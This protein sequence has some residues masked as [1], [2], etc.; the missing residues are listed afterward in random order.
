MRSERSATLGVDART[1]G[2]R[3]RAERHRQALTL[4]QLAERCNLT[5]STLSQIERGQSD[6]TLNSLRSIAWALAI[7][8]FQLVISSP[9]PDLVVRRA[10]RPTI[11]TQEGHVA[12]QRV[13]ADGAVSF[14]V[15]SA[16]FPPGRA[17]PP[18]AGGHPYEECV[19]VQ[20]GQIVV[21]VADQQFTLEDG[22]SITIDRDVPH[23]YANSGPT[24]AEILMILSPRPR[25]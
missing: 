18:V 24:D 16:I 2:E 15:L 21:T 23:R 17:D 5:I 3:I 12:Y 25:L 13:A 1:I 11:R 4:A 10:D 9:R 14:E 22:D 8:M 20:R 6:P 19:V 7:P